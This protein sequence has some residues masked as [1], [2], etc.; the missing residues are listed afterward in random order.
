MASRFEGE[1]TIDDV[2]AAIADHARSLKPG[3]HIAANTYT[4]QFGR[5][6]TPR[7]FAK[8]N[9]LGIIRK[10]GKSMAGTTLWLAG[11]A[12]A[13]PSSPISLDEPMRE[14]ARRYGFKNP[15]FKGKLGT[16][17]RFAECVEEME[18][19]PGVYDPEGLCAAIG[20][21]KYGGK[22][23]AR[24][25]TKGRRRNPK[26]STRK[27]AT[28]AGSRY[29]VYVGPTLAYVTTRK[30]DAN[31]AASKLKLSGRAGITIKAV[32]PNPVSGK[33]PKVGWRAAYRKA[34]YAAV[35]A[36]GARRK[37][38]RT[39]QA[40][41]R[42]V[43]ASANPYP[44]GV[45]PWMAIYR[46]SPKF[47][48]TTKAALKKKMDR[49][50]S[51]TFE[52]QRYYKAS[53]IGKSFGEWKTV[54]QYNVIAKRFMM[55]NPA[56]RRRNGPSVLVR[57]NAGRNAGYQFM[58]RDRDSIAKSFPWRS[59]EQAAMRDAEKLAKRAGVSAVNIWIRA[60]GSPDASVYTR[61]SAADLGRGAGAGRRS[62][63]RLRYRTKVG[64]RYAY[65][66]SFKVNGKTVRWVRYAKD[67]YQAEEQAQKAIAR[68]YPGDRVT[69]LNIAASAAAQLANPRKRR[70]VSRS[71]NPKRPA[72]AVYVGDKTAWV[73]QAKS[74][75]NK[76]VAML[77]DAGRSA[78]KLYQVKIAPTVRMGW[79]AAFVN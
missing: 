55:A 32:G 33:V 7:A 14:S 25:A 48:A 44:Q 13:T 28:K 24:M 45:G 23:M 4:W 67:I 52:V 72:Y 64:D 16:G 53:T 37:A 69:G 51:G 17:Q 78:V 15:A 3:Q 22:G 63:P 6:L 8:A 65:R 70:P 21:R 5:S 36:P 56:S 62:N 35:K 47:R 68:E 73:G 41:R 10:A 50:G 2:V 58:A 11:P 46:G 18:S 74:A 79:R 39:T 1:V 42:G 40:I 76:A 71:A 75:A 34:A 57:R 9:K 31:K 54:G 77:E 49:D 12:T 26:T 20:K 38:A 29:G 27:A 59:T 30:L 61:I 60:K 43:R 19:R 66:V